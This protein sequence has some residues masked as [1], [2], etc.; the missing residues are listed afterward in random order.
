MKVLHRVAAPQRPAPPHSC[1]SDLFA[2]EFEENT[3]GRLLPPGSVV[4]CNC[5]VPYIKEVAED[6][7]M[8]VWVIN[9]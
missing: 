8:E 7:M 1:Q 2:F 9:K 6:T 3:A 5:T 4:E